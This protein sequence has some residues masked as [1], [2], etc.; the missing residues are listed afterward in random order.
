MTLSDI[1][2]GTPGKLP[3]KLTM[4]IKPLT[5]TI[6]SQ[7][8]LKKYFSYLAKLDSFKIYFLSTFSYNSDNDKMIK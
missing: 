8:L 6:N 2:K 4:M 1:S 7:L 3:T 5:N